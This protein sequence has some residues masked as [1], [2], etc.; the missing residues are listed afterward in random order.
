[1]K[2]ARQMLWYPV[3]YTILI[4]PI[5]GARFAAFAGKEV[6]YEVTIFADTVFMLSGFV[7]AVLFTTTRRVVP[8]SVI[9]PKFIRE[10]FG[11]TTGSG[12]NT[13]QRSFNNTGI[14]SRATK[15]PNLGIGISVNIEKDVE[16]DLD[17]S[18]NGG[19]YRMSQRPVH[20]LD[21]IAPFNEQ[22]L[23]SRM[24]AGRTI[25]WDDGIKAPSTPSRKR[26]S[27]VG[28]TN[29][30]ASGA[31]AGIEGGIPIAMEYPSP[32]HSYQQSHPPIHYQPSTSPN[33]AAY[34]YARDRGDRALSA[35]YGYAGQDI[36]S[37]VDDDRRGSAHAL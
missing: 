33:V 35:A 18:Y 36:T 24:A 16:Y 12:M 25:V 29:S 8:A 13:Q 6:P 1:M 22:T 27:S 2:V 23:G 37:A 21:N 32:L 3:V 26:E 34:L 20:P 10:R 19:S 14:S 9:F 11:I 5:A 4:V 30:D 7:N 31:R 28:S 15:Y 17:G